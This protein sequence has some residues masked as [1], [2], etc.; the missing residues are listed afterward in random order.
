MRCPQCGAVD[1]R[2]VDS[3]PAED[4]TAI[5]RRREC[6]SCGRRFTTYERLAPVLVVRKRDGHLEPFSGVKLR[7]GV[8]SAVADRP[9]AP[10]QV[11]SLLEEIEATVASAGG[12]VSSDAIGSWV[13]AGLRTIDEVAYLRFASVYE[14]FEGPDDFERALEE[15]EVSSER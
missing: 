13:L 8:E 2:V 15:L 12:P 9:V 5:R 3:R 6:V 11:D 4:Q 10:G 14:D 7:A 1:S